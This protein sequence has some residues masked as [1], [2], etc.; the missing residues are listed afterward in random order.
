MERWLG[1][2]DFIKPHDAEIQRIA[3]EVV[4][5]ERDALAAARKLSEWVF[6]YVETQMIA[7]T[8]SGPDVLKRK[9]GKCSEYTTLFASLAR[10]AGI[11]TRVALGERIAAGSWMGHMWNEVYVGSWIP[12]DASANEVG[13]GCALLK[14]IHSDSVMG[15]QALRWALTESLDL[16]VEA[17]ERQPV[18][19]ADEYTTGVAG[20]VYT[21]AEYACRLTCPHE[22]W[23]LKTRDKAG[24]AIVRLE[25]PER[26]EVQVHFVA[27]A[28]PAGMT[29]EALIAPRKSVFENNYAEFEMRAEERR[30]IAGRPGRMMSF[31]RAP[32]ESETEPMRTTEFVWIC[33]TNGYLLNIIAP[34]AGHDEFIGAVEALLGE[35]EAL[36][37]TE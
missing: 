11:P 12:V 25:I 19:L 14:F 16:A 20:S 24:A 36:G 29:P 2:T 13:G 17:F 6:G 15:T 1:E 21:N 32:L 7:E 37:K 9:V 31:D 30:E 3:R 8:L 22:G 33:G 26:D 28:L 10:A 18:A 35:F 27:F 23:Q 34:V 4:G 5:D